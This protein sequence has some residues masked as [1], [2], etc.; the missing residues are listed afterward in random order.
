L[1]PELPPQHEKHLTIHANIFI[2]MRGSF[3]TSVL[4]EQPVK[5]AVLQ[6]THEQGA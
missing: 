3:K 6:E 2:I 1:N 4:K 5:N